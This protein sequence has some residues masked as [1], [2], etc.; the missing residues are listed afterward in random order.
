MNTA[1]NH[2]LIITDSRGKPIHGTVVYFQP[3]EERPRPQTAVVHV[4]A[5]EWLGSYGYEAIYSTP[6]QLIPGR[7]TPH[8]YSAVE[9]QWL[10]M[11]TF[12]IPA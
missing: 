4:V 3:I 7:Y 1:T 10:L 9:G 8:G 11:G 6:D 2:Y 12:D 5:S